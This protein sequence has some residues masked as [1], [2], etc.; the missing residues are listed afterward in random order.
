MFT[1]NMAGLKRDV[2]MA[3]GWINMR[4]MLTVDM[5]AKKYLK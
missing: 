2:Y 3:H 4:L 5:E 1:W